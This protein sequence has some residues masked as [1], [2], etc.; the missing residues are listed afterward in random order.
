MNF[1]ES[2]SDLGRLLVIAAIVYVALLAGLRVT[3]SRALAKMSAYDLV[4]TIAL[5]S[6]VAT[7]ILQDSVAVVSG[8][9]AI[10]ALLVLQRLTAWIVTRWPGARRIVKGDPTL[11]LYEGRILEDRLQRV[12]ITEMEVR[13]AVRAAGMLSM[14]E[15]VAVVLENDGSWS[16]MGRS[17]APDRSA[18]EGLDLPGR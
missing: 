18:L 7:V 6:L 9:G 16:V 1:F 8:V 13:A 3:G 2:W 11:V 14:S 15:A 10:G 12:K 5:G 4:V 17:D